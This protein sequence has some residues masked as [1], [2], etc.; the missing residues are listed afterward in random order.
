[1]RKPI[2]DFHPL[3]II[4]R[5]FAL[6]DDKWPFLVSLWATFGKLMLIESGGEGEKAKY[7]KACWQTVS[8]S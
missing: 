5:K 3:G 6:A 7:A 2:K 4:K 8:K 1:M